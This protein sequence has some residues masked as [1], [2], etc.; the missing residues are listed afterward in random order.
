[1]EANILSRINLILAN[2]A[3]LC[4]NKGCSYT[5]KFGDFRSL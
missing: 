3:Y 4:R 2:Y 5:L 1:M